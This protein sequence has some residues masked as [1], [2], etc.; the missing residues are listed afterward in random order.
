M[1]TEREKIIGLEGFFMGFIMGDEI[2][3]KINCNNMVNADPY[4]W[5][6]IFPEVP[7][8]KIIKASNSTS[9]D[10]DVSTQQPLLELHRLPSGN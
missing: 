1:G 4:G 10:G 3:K 6:Y 8:V 2:F 5:F 7:V 9:T